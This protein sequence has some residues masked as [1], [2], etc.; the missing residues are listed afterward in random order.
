M[1]LWFG[2]VLLIVAGLLYLSITAP[3]QSAFKRLIN[4]NKPRPYDH[5]REP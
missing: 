3:P 5:E 1:Q 2:I 4:R